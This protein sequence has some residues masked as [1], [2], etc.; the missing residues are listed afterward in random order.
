MQAAAQFP[1]AAGA[2]VGVGVALAPLRTAA[3]FAVK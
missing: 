1:G 2:G 3:A